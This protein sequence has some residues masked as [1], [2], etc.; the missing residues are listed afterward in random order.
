M[1]RICDNIK[2][3]EY[4]EWAYATLSEMIMCSAER[5]MIKEDSE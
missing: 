3:W 4:C 1:S 5:C 2:K